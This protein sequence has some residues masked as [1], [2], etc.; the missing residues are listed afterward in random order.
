MHDDLDRDAAA[1]HAALAAGDLTAARL[2]AARIGAA[3]DAADETRRGA[4]IRALFAGVVEP[5][6]DRLDADGRAAYATVFPWAIHGAL[7]S[8]PHCAA[9]MSACEL[10]DAEALAAGY[11]ARRRTAAAPP[12]L[13]AGVRRV[14]V[15]SRVTLG[16][17]IAIT[18]VVLQR[19]HQALPEAE[20]VLLGDGKLSGLL[21]GLPGVRVQPLTY[22]RRGRLGERLRSWPLLRAAI[23]DL[24][25]DLVVAPDSR[26]DQ[27]GLLPVIDGARYRLWENIPAPGESLARCCDRWLRGWLPA[28][29]LHPGD[30]LPTLGLDPAAAAQAQRWRQL[31]AGGP[32]LAV[33]LDHGGNPAKALVATEEA[34]LLR[35][36]AASGWRILLDRGFGS[37]ELRG[38]DALCAA[39][40]LVPLDLD[41]SGAGLGR[42]PKHLE[43]A[44]VAT[45]S[46]LRFHGSI[47][48]WAAAVTGCRAALAYDSVGNHL[49]AALGVPLV[50]IF[51]GH[52]GVRFLDAWRPTGPAPIRVI[53]VGAGDDATAVRYAVRGALG[54]VGLGTP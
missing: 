44:S 35:E 20:L 12:P 31:L 1:L 18:S 47:A 37:D 22:P 40:G 36:L 30:C 33:K 24:G 14:A 53:A 4:G 48:G 27:L 17:D 26:L 3:A 49:A 11:A 9:A 50:T 7:A 23:A 32:W 54:P 42:D 41:D 51:A 8:E 10:S 43:A 16:A 2:V 45:A 38:S 25:A 13:P 19:L 15:L 5:L 29:T 34:Q 39:A 52:A 28:E 46:V 6:C 21:G